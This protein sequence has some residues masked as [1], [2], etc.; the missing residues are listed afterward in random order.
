MKKFLI[1]ISS[2]LAVIVIGFIT[3]IIIGLNTDS[4]SLELEKTYIETQDKQDLYKLCTALQ[5]TNYHEKIVDYY[6]LLLNDYDF[7]NYIYQDSYWSDSL[8]NLETTDIISTYIIT[9]LDAVLT[10]SG[11]EEYEKQFAIYAPRIAFNIYDNS[12][13]VLNVFELHFYNESGIEISGID[14]EKT[15]TYLT[16]LSDY[17]NK[18]KIDTTRKD[19][20]NLFI[21]SWYSEINNVDKMNQQRSLVSKQFTSC[22]FFEWEKE[23]GDGYTLAFSSADKK[24]LLGKH[25]YSD[26]FLIDIGYDIKQYAFDYRYIYIMQ[27]KDNNE[28]Y[29]IIDTK[30]HKISA[31][32]NNCG[33]FENECLDL[34]MAPELKDIEQ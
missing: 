15:N 20:I 27:I 9:Y 19:Y 30:T 26:K 21:Y 7:K 11:I 33:D 5:E 29:Y 10:I 24:A 12:M 3:L 18:L 2:I 13:P 32:Y 1:I 22:D 28:Y 31:P 16:L 6:P 25:N 17:I 23:L 4:E 8:V 34:G 14:K